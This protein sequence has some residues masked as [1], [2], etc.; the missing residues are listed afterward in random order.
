MYNLELEKAII[1]REEG[2]EG[3]AEKLWEVC[4]GIVRGHM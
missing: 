3:K 4:W 1:G 2:G